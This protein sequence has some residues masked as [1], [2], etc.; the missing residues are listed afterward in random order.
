[1][2]E[3]RTLISIDDYDVPEFADLAAS[4]G[5]S[6]YGF[7]VTP[8]VDHLIRYHEEQE[9]RAIYAAADYVLLD[10]RFLSNVLRVSRG[11]NIRVCPGSDL[12]DELFR[13]VIQKDDKVIVIGGRPWQVEW[14][15]RHYN[16]GNIEHFNPPMGFIRDYGALEACLDFV[17][18]HSPFRFCFL[19][20]G[21]PQQ[22]QVAQQLKARGRATGLALCVGASI[23]FLTGAQR[24]APRWMQQLGMEW[25]FRALKDPVRLGKRY[26]VRG[27][28]IFPLLQ[29][30]TF[31]LRRAH[32]GGAEYLDSP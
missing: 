5:T 30:Y 28:S 20:V 3:L 2:K 6:R 1:V 25:L 13:H 29:R 17:E 9:F 27:P 15:A 23:D 19:A 10:S 11:I 14:L 7:V 12:T 31:W 4:F 32:E 18:A 21:C 26:F 8:N 24:R 16:L 22:E